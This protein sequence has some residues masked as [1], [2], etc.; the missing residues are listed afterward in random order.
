MEES[1]E[2]LCAVIGHS[3]CA[4]EIELGQIDVS[5]NSLL[6]VNAVIQEN[7][8]KLCV[9]S[10]ATHSIVKPGLLSVP[11]SAE[12]IVVTAKKL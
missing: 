9:D 1:S 4:I 10:G 7:K 12:P 11:P 2:N 8:L 3:V 5:S 6:F